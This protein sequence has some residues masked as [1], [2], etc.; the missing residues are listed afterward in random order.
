[1]AFDV[2][3][4]FLPSMGVDMVFDM[5]SMSPYSRSS[6]IYD[7]D[8][9]NQNI[10]IAQPLTPFS[11]N[12]SYKELHITTLLRE[13]TRKIRIGIKCDQ[14]KIIDQY[15]L[16]NNKNVKAVVINYALPATETNI[17]AAFRLPTASKFIIKAKIIYNGLD[18][19]TP[20][21]FSIRDI[22]LTGLG[23]AI[24]KKRINIINPLTEIKTNQEIIIGIILVNR[25]EIEPIAAFP[26]K[27]K[28][29]RINPNYSTTH[30]SMGMQILRLK[31]SNEDILNKFIHNA[32]IDELKK[33]S[34]RD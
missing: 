19:F 28:I 31:T 17:S 9:K 20:N 18:Y 3:K 30:C 8:Y 15:P 26:M 14:F 22:S 16:A 27:A 6:I 4:I 32:Q 23:I 13:K 33:L 7:V 10:T 5:N 12:T 11:K 1:M 25:N 21:D 24:P 2:N 34:R 29:A